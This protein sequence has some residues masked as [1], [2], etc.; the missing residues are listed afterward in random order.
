MKL[1]EDKKYN[2]YNRPI[3]LK[4]SLLPKIVLTVRSL[5]IV[6][7]RIFSGKFVQILLLEEVASFCLYFSSY[8][9]AYLLLKAVLLPFLVSYIY[10]ITRLSLLNNFEIIDLN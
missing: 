7:L 8:I 4:T 2:E 1:I 6:C 3:D 9:K 10:I 5:N